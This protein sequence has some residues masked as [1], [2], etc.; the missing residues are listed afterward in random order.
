MTDPA[1]GDTPHDPAPGGPNPGTPHPPTGGEGAPEA[2]PPEGEV[3]DDKKAEELPEGSKTAVMP[4]RE[5]LDLDATPAVPSTVVVPRDETPELT[6]EARAV[7]DEGDEAKKDE[8]ESDKTDEGPSEGTASETTATGGGGEMPPS[9]GTETAQGG[10]EPTPPKGGKTQSDRAKAA[11]TDATINLVAGVGAA[12]VLTEALM[13]FESMLKIH[14]DHSGNLEDLMPFLQIMTGRVQA[15][16]GLVGKM[17]ENDLVK[18][19]LAR[20]GLDDPVEAN[21]IRDRA[22]KPVKDGERPPE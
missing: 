11:I 16:M 20:V 12:A 7:L 9:G 2:K 15:Y 21:A 8:L 13:R 5:V 4:P 22:I 17:L 1:K 10:E 6:D 18:A 14:D 19:A 3:K